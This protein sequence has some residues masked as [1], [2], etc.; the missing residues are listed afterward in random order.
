MKVFKFGGASV[1]DAD[2]VRNMALIIRENQG[3]PLVV[4]VSAMGKITNALENLLTHSL[5]KLDSKAVALQKIV[6]FHQQIVDEL[7]LDGDEKLQAEIAGV[8][9]GL[10]YQL[11][12]SEPGSSY[13]LLYDQ[14]VSLGEILSTLI[15]AAY[16]NHNDIPTHW[17]DARKVI[18]TDQTYSAA[19]VDWEATQN[20]IQSNINQLTDR[21]VVLSQGFIGSND[22]SNTTTLGR[23]GSD[24]TGAIFAA[25]LSAESLT[26]WKDVPGVLNA[27]PKKFKEAQKYDRLPYKEAAEMSY[28][29]TSVIH[30]KTIK[31]LAQKGI[32]LYV[33]SFKNP[34]APGTLIDECVVPHLKPA[35]IVKDRQTLIFLKISDFSLINER[36]IQTIFQEINRLNLGINFM[37]KSPTSFTFCMDDNFLKREELQDALMEDFL[38]NYK[39]GLKLMTVKNYNQKT[40]DEL[41]GDK[42]III[43]QRSGNNF[44]M[45]YKC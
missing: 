34:Q 27:D 40:L 30:P 43:E 45:V 20:L 16:L 6:S 1:K 26:I 3:A 31:P 11:D 2:A 33:K 24:F 38:F 19:K 8:Y 22:Q 13:D 7:G 12:Q 10:N 41:M 36:H 18:K 21:G 5:A 39:E 17:L 4:I 15:I 35:I 28:Y 23:E 42:D 29:G 32:P 25:A 37:Q 44:Q 9:K 14:T